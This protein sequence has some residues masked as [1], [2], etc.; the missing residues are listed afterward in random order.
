MIDAMT[1]V[2]REIARLGAIFDQD[3][4]ART[5][6]LYAPCVAASTHDFPLSP[7]VAYGDHPRQKMDVYGCLGARHAPVLL[8]VPGGG[9]VSGDKKIDEIF[10]G[11]IGR[12]FAQRGVL[13]FVMNY[14]LA[15]E[16]QWP[17]GGH[18]VRDAIN[19]IHAH[20]QGLGGDPEN[21]TLFGQS[22]GAAHVASYLFH[23]EVRKETLLAT[24]AVLASGVYDLSVRPMPP[25]F[26]L[27][28]GE[29]ESCHDS[30]GVLRHVG[31]ADVPLLLSYSE[32]DPPFLA[33][34]TLRLAEAIANQ[35]GKMP[36]I[37][38]LE[39]HN[40][41]SNVLSFGSDDDS[42]GNEILAF[43]NER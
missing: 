37:V 17:A 15:P 36:K 23:P 11:N 28:Y 43:I 40:H 20:A 31:N 33:I 30:R 7:D 39:G 4:N 26:A 35:R 25:G 8:F 18:D 16:S 6:A 22:A 1:S 5:R 29:D 13:T 19:W 2:K 21:L 38:Y 24:R 9:F 10:Y 42:Y 14:R 41:V 3:I 34:P 32:F 12:W 27:Y